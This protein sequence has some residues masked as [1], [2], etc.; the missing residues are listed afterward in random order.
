MTYPEWLAWASESRQS[1]WEDG[2]AIPFPPPT[3]RDARA[4][5]AVAV[6]LGCCVE[7]RRLGTPIIA[8]F[9]MRPARSAREPDVVVVTAANLARL[10]EERLEGPADL[11][12]EVVA[13][14]SE[15]RDMVTKFAEYADAGASEYW[16]GD[17]RPGRGTL[18]GFALGP[19]GYAP[20]RPDPGGRMPSL[21]LPGFRFDPAR[22]RER[23]P[24]PQAALRSVLPERFVG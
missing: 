3:I 4:R 14:D 15:H 1:E 22:F 2:W 23:A 5:P 7:E 9:E 10:T 24:D 11:I 8:P 16:I 12:Q 13:D 17:P 21:L 6:V 19:A 18:D 20:I